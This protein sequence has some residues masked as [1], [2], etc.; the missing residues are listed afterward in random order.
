MASK[1]KAICDYL[2]TKKPVKSKKELNS[3]L[4]DSLRIDLSLFLELD[5][6]VIID[7]CDLYH[8]TNLKYFKKIA[9]DYKNGKYRYCPN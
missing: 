3:L 4:F 8:N 2:Y 5:F 1:E 6:D 9:E 7:L